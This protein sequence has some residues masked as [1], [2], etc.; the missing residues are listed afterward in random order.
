MWKLPFL[1]LI[2]FSIAHLEVWAASVTSEPYP[3]K[4]VRIVD[5]YAPGGNTDA[6]ARVI[7][8]KMQER[9]GQRV[10]VENR[11]GAGSTIGAEFVVRSAP[12]G[13]TMFI[14]LGTSLS[15][16]PFLYPKLPYNIVDDFSYVTL[17][18]MGSYIVLVHPSL[19]AKNMAELVA[20]TKSKPMEFRYGTGGVGS[21][22]HLLV[23]LLKLRTGLRASHV[24]YKGGAPAAVAA[25]GG[26][27]EINMNS[28]AGGFGMVL[29]KKLIALAVTGPNR[30]SALPDIPTMAE[31]GIA[32]YQIRDP[33]GLVMPSRTPSAMIALMNAELRIILQMDDVKA[34]F[35]EQGI[36]VMSSSP[37]EYKATILKEQERWGRVIKEADIP[38]NL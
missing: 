23:E 25:A 16:S 30:L 8:A 6:L 24:P 5:G 15:S 33:I 21:G 18:G 10:L 38:P 27:V 35:A 3:S 14:A 31:S 37:E 11:V 19:P 4:L 32:D 2:S 34:R 26:E 13:H 9:L 20:L 28:V 17:V 1:A 29:S 7:G 22:P 36:E 12:D